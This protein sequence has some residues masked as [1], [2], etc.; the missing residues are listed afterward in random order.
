MEVDE[1][2]S[3]VERLVAEVTEQK[4]LAENY[5]EM[6]E[7]AKT[8]A[9]ALAEIINAYLRAFPELEVI[10]AGWPPEDYPRTSAPRG[11]EAVRQVLHESP[12]TWWYVSELVEKLR[13]RGALPDS[14]NP[15]NA[16]RTALER[17]RSN[18]ESDVEK[19]VYGTKVAYRYQPDEEA[20]PEPQSKPRYSPIDPGPSYDYGEEPF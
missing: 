16:I 4:D 17:L 12:G 7:A 5:L 20:P 13:E 19:G 15:A 6:A 10:V 3:R 1:A 14:D 9:G 11:A 8:R 2:A 18:P